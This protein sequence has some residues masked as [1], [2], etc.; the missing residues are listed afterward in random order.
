[1]LQSPSPG[2]SLP[3]MAATVPPS[4]LSPLPL[5]PGCSLLPAKAATVSPSAAPPPP[6]LPLHLPS[7]AASSLLSPFLPRLPLYLPQVLSPTPFLSFSLSPSTNSPLN[8]FLPQDPL[9][10]LPGSKGL[11]LGSLR[12]CGL[13]PPFKSAARDREGAPRH[14]SPDPCLP[15]SA[16][17]DGHTQ[18]QKPSYIASTET[19]WECSPT[20]QRAQQC[21]CG[22]YLSAAKPR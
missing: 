2:S 5:F 7:P 18:T 22:R 19:S 16:V 8:C 1:M 17:P 3:P 4:V 13:Q 11:P 10:H 21:C 20:T 6:P 9:P 14:G 15:P 12:G